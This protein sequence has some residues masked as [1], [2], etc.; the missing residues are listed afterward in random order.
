[1]C[2]TVILFSV[3]EVLIQTRL[4]ELILKQKYITKIE[5]LLL[6]LNECRANLKGSLLII[7]SY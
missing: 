7:I 5:S 4:V 3:K 6:P 1:M 2:F